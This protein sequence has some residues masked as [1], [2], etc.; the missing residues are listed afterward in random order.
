MTV[1]QG[2]TIVLYSHQ[3]LREAMELLLAHTMDAV[4]IIDEHG[5]TIGRCTQRMLLWA[6][7]REMDRTTPIRNVLAAFSSEAGRED[8]GAETMCMEVDSAAAAELERLRHELEEA[9]RLAET[10]KTVLD[11]AYEGVVVVDGNGVIREINR[12]YC[13]FLGIRRE[14]AVGKHVTDVI[15]NTRLH[16]CVQSGIPERG[17]IQKIYGQPM[18]VHRIPI[19]RDGKVIGAIGMLIFQGVSEVYEIFRRLQELSRE[20]S[21]KEKQ[22]TEAKP[23]ETAASAPKGIERIIGRHPAIAAVK[24]MIRRAAR[25]P[26][27]VLITGESGTGKEVVARAIH[28]AGPHADG[29]FVSVNCAAIPE[30]LLEAELFGYEDGAF[31]G[32]KK[33]GK[34][35]KFQLAHRGTLFLDEIGDMPLAMQAKILRALE[36][37]KVEKVGGL[38]ETEVDVRIIAATNKPLEEMVRN[39]T[40]RE[41]L[42]YRLNIIRI[43]LPPLRER[44]T[45]IP[46]LLAY[47][48]ERMCRQF[49]VA[50]KSFTKEAME[51]L[52]HYSWPG[53]VRELVNVVEWLIS[54]VEGDV[55]EREHLPAYLSTVQ[56]AVS[57]LPD[58][59][60]RIADLWKEMV[61]QSERERI[62]AALV[63]AGG[64]KTE[65]ARRLGIHRSTLYEKLKKYG[66]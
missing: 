18:V 58:Q 1:G 27:T 11:A 4:D 5:R 16:I 47:H 41:D 24:Q 59:G 7:A 14:E 57:A 44:K 6:A 21:R 46:A 3:T 64:N 60:V 20:A 17:Y 54:M 40:F 23:Q 61:Y 66:L 43:H 51:V 15:E 29:P 65:A 42:F 28:E 53:N 52:V 10:M 56:P 36:E 2:T 63:A 9:H 13:Q 55:I 45:D 48:M 35:G 31:T 22:E 50:L 39:G 37:K 30:S 26:S 12:A 25:V 38:Y 19:W 34:P 32:A 49:G 8:S 33:G 62:A